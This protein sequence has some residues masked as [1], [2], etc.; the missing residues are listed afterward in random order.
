MFIFSHFFFLVYV[1]LF[2][3]RDTCLFKLILL[4]VLT[5]IIYFEWQCFGQRKG[6]SLT[7]RNGMVLTHFYSKMSQQEMG[8]IRK[9]SENL[10]LHENHVN[11]IYI[12]LSVKMFMVK[13]DF[14]LK[15]VCMYVL[16]RYNFCLTCTENVTSFY[17][18]NFI[19]YLVYFLIE[20]EGDLTSY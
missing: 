16:R 9:Q 19:V 2:T 6:F 10:P 8:V 13:C 20:S 15:S 4:V 3:W 1:K 14:Y 11:K 5:H 7:G 12:F 18:Y 17:K